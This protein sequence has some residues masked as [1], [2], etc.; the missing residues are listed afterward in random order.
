MQCWRKLLRVHWTSRTNHSIP[1]EVHQDTSKEAWP[2]KLKYFEGNPDYC[3]WGS[4]R[5]LTTV[6]RGAIK[7]LFAWA[8]K[9]S[10]KHYWQIMLANDHEELEVFKWMIKTFQYYFSHQSFCNVNTTRNMWLSVWN[11]ASFILFVEKFFSSC[12]NVNYSHFF[13]L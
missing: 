8:Y 12:C 2:M 13:S 9:V 7:T 3:G 11:M 4:G 1:D 10:R 5:E 6:E